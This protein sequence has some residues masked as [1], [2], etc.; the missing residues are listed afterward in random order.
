MRKRFPLRRGVKLAKPSRSAEHL[1][2]ADGL[3]GMA[4]MLDRRRSSPLGP[5]D[6]DHVEPAA[7][8]QKAVCLEEMESRQ[9]QP[10]LFFGRHRLGRHPFTTGLFLDKD[11]DIA[12][13]G[14]QVDLSLADPVA[15]LQDAHPGPAQEPGGLALPSVAQPAVPEGSDDRVH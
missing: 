10:S 3:E 12:V 11:Q 7:L 8:V 15:S 1:A 13:P 2:S 9:G 14:D 6:G 4:E 5:D